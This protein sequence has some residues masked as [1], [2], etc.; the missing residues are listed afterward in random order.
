MKSSKRTLI[1]FCVIAVLFTI[2]LVWN[3]TDGSLP[4]ARAPLFIGL[5]LVYAAYT[6]MRYFN[7]RKEEE[8]KTKK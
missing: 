2:M 8:Q 6:C 3:L 7:Y 1:V 4:P 5:F